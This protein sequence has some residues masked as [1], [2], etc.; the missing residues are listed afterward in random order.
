MR[1]GLIHGIKIRGEFLTFIQKENEAVKRTPSLHQALYG[2]RSVA[3]HNHNI[4]TDDDAFSTNLVKAV[5][6]WQKLGY[7]TDHMTQLVSVCTVLVL[8]S[9]CKLSASTATGDRRYRGC[10]RQVASMILQSMLVSLAAQAA[11]TSFNTVGIHSI[12][13]YRILVDCLPL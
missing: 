1:A 5:A 12:S 13:H 8:M 7:T 9:L 6:K 10:E 4:L 2:A 11:L 3:V